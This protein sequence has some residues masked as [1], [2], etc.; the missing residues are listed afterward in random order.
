MIVSHGLYAQEETIFLS[1][2]IHAVTGYTPWKS[3]QNFRKEYNTTNAESISNKLGSLSPQYGFAAGLDCFVSNHLYCAVDYMNLSS[4]TRASF[5]NGAQRLIQA[6]TKII[7]SNIGW[8]QPTTSGYWTLTTGFS[9]AFGNLKSFIEFPDGT[10]YKHTSGLSGEFHDVNIG[11]SLNFE[12][13]KQLSDRIFWR[14]GASTNFFFETTDL[15]MQNTFVT[16]TAGSLSLNSTQVNYDISG[17]T[18]YTGLAFKLY[19]L[20]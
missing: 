8:L 7:N 17:L 18:I 16:Q 13:N 11:I 9:A 14:T 4:R 1:G 15:G 3:F 12:W 6:N 10:R 2:E 19:I 20:E 5:T